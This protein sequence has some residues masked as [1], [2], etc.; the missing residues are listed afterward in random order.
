MKLATSNLPAAPN[1]LARLV[2]GAPATAKPVRPDA[3][4]TKAWS[5]AVK[6]DHGSASAPSAANSRSNSSF[7]QLVTDLAPET[8]KADANPCAHTP[9]TAVAVNPDLILVSGGGTPVFDL[10]DCEMPAFNED[11][12]SSEGGAD[13]VLSTATGSPV[14]DVPDCVMP[15]FSNPV[16]GRPGLGSTDSPTNSKPVFDAPNCKT[17]TFPGDEIPGEQSSDEPT[18]NGMPRDKP[19]KAPIARSSQ[20]AEVTAPISGEQLAVSGIAI[21][22]PLDLP[23]L[24]PPSA[25]PA[26]NAGAAPGDQSLALSEGQSSTPSVSWTTPPGL[27]RLMAQRDVAALPTEDTFNTAYASAEAASVDSD[28]ASATDWAANPVSSEQRTALSEFSSAHEAAEPT[29]STPG[30]SANAREV[31]ARSL[32]FFTSPASEPT[33]AITTD[34]VESSLPLPE[35]TDEA[36]TNPVI[37]V[38]TPVLAVDLAARVAG[39]TGLATA[40]ERHRRITGADA[41]EANFAVGDEAELPPTNTPAADSKR[42]FLSTD[43]ESSTAR[44]KMLGID[45]AKQ[46]ATMFARFLPTPPQHPASEYAAAAVAASGGMLESVVPSHVDE[47]LSQTL[48]SAHDAVEVVLDAADRAASQQ[49]KSVNLQFSIGGT[50]LAVRVQ[51]HANEVRATFRTDSAELRAALSHEWQSVESTS[52]GGDRSFRLAPPVFTA[53]DHSALNSFAGDASSRQRDQQAERLAGEH[54]SS[55]S[56]TRSPGAAV[57][58]SG[59]SSAGSPAASLTS[60]HLHTLA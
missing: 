13:D 56:R 14:F 52:A 6:C 1:L 54:A 29:P 59:S 24:P 17:P 31:Y 48:G 3:V 16:S 30:N 7:D 25:S 57:P 12:L 21:P 32:G 4:K 20:R 38:N 18:V 45:G 36:L 50:E 28:E 8:P 15:G 44:R 11:G 22:L 60:R 10:P 2:P 19:W 47:L 23:I 35:T 40:A 9:A 43:G 26:P 5:A 49:Q 34:A 46:D 37:D 51:L 58:V 41:R 33:H 27:G 53:P 55:N 42:S 39:E